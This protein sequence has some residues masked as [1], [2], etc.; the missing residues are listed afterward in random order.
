MTSD[1]RELGLVEESRGDPRV[2]VCHR[3]RSRPKCHTSG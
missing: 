1:S 3:L 2:T